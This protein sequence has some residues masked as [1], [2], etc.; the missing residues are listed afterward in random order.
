MEHS[1]GGCCDKSLPDQFDASASAVACGDDC[2]SCP[3]SR[4]SNLRAHRMVPPPFLSF[5]PWLWEAI[6]EFMGMFLMVKKKI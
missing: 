5:A 3:S 2:S 6:A 4:Q 1:H